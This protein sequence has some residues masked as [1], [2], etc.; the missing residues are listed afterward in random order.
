[1]R[2]DDKGRKR[3]AFRYTFQ[4][5]KEGNRPASANAVTLANARAEAMKLRDAVAVAA[6]TKTFA[7][8]TRIVIKRDKVGWGLKSLEAGSGRCSI[9]PNRKASTMGSMSIAL[10]SFGPRRTDNIYAYSDNYLVD[11]KHAVIVDVEATTVIRQGRSE[12]S[13][14][15]RT[16]Q[17]DVHARRSSRRRSRV[18]A[19]F[20]GRL[21][22][23]RSSPAPVLEGEKQQR[24]EGT[25]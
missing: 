13:I 9:T 6:T 15:D 19:S 17:F 20:A 21:R 25:L 14:L 2:A 10:T 23:P 7:E 12:R 18:R 3:W 8:V 1:M 22:P 4:G 11:L 5:Q 16:A 24:R